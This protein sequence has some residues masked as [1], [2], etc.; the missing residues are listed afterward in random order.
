[1]E[2][3]DTTIGSRSIANPLLPPTRDMPQWPQPEIS[4]EI[5]PETVVSP[6][7]NILPPIMGGGGWDLPVGDP[8][9]PTGMPIEPE[10]PDLVNPG[11]NI[12]GYRD[13]ITGRLL[14]GILDPITDR[15]KDDWR[16]R[17]DYTPVDTTT[18]VEETP[19][20]TP[21]ETFDPSTTLDTGGDVDLTG[22]ETGTGT[23]GN[24]PPAQETT[25]AGTELEKLLDESV[26]RDLKGESTEVT[27]ARHRLDREKS[28]NMEQA[29]RKAHE[30]AVRAGYRPGTAQYDEIV[31]KGISDAHNANIDA[32][33]KFNEFAR[34]VRKESYQ[35]AAD[36]GD[37]DYGRGRDARDDYQ[38]DIDRLMKNIPTD[39]GRELLAW[40]E[41][42]GESLNKVL[43]T[44]RDPE[45]GEW[46]VLD[47]TGKQKRRK[48]FDEEMAGLKYNPDTNKPWTSE[49]EYT[50]YTEKLWSQITENIFDPV[51]TQ[52]DIKDEQVAGEARFEEF[53]KSGDASG[54]EASDWENVTAT[55]ISD[56]KKDGKII[57]LNTG[58]ATGMETKMSFDKDGDQ[59]IPSGMALNTF[60]A[61]NP[62]AEVG[63]V[64]EIDGVLYEVTEVDTRYAGKVLNT[65]KRAYVMGKPVKPPGPAKEIYSSHKYD[66]D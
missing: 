24:L 65:R 38:E 5:V 7:R 46:L 13:P 22:G 43:N 1:M 59:S 27:A 64:V 53:L 40:G 14:P 2:K 50:D 18:P 23:E 30:R 17:I 44:M 57:E 39:K 10:I 54:L 62:W 63:N 36:I 37:R 45:T 41:V 33:N 35:S 49:Q 34:G 12:T 32:E 28:I 9:D 21:V 19:V 51:T 31:R 3:P 25:G 20:E 26:L 8:T 16:G 48:V 55:Q 47:D 58:S 61:D 42:N 56:A 11:A 15:L 6:Q 60:K 52:G 29:Q 4:K 66:P